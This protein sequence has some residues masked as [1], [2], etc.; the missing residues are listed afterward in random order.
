[1]FKRNEMIQ[2]QA[3]YMALSRTKGVYLKKIRSLIMKKFKTPLNLINAPP[4]ELFPYFRDK[5][6]I[7]KITGIKN[8]KNNIL[9]RMNKI[10]NECLDVNIGVL[11]Y[12]DEDYPE[13]VRNLK[14][15]PQILFIKGKI[16]PE[17][18]NSFSIIGT[19]NPSHYGHQKTREIAYDLAKENYTIISG[20]ARGIDTE[21]HLGALDA[22]GRTIAVVGSGISNIYPPENQELVEDIAKNGAIITESLPNE[23]V[24]KW[25]LQKRNKLNCGLSLGS[26]FI[27]GTRTSGTK[28]QIKFAKEQNKPIFGLN[29]KDPDRKNSYIPLYVINELNGYK[30][31]SAKDVLMKYKI[32]MKKYS[33]KNETLF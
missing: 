9:S 7:L 32:W 13:M 18:K 17:D 2:N 29:P 16:L 19:R 27:E 5:E 1:M 3:I 4:E 28:W 23:S 33:K 22:G 31:S 30:I 14:D 6:T 12:F 11:T 20:L 26:I 10:I 15:P 21:A 8:D 24:K 25:T